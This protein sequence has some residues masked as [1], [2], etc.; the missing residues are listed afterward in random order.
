[1][2]RLSVLLEACD[3]GGVDHSAELGG[4]EAAA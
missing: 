2:Q 3:S 1:M 4:D